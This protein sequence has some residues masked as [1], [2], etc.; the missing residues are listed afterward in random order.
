MHILWGD[1]T[2]PNVSM[3]TC[4]QCRGHSLLKG[5]SLA[6]APEYW[7]NSYG[8]VNKG[9]LNE[10]GDGW[11]LLSTGQCLVQICSLANL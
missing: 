11:V 1:C 7:S 5:R 4:S 8:E 3:L 10:M 6:S 2:S 9:L